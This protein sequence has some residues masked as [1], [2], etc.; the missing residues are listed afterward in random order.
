MDGLEVRVHDTAD[1]WTDGGYLGSL[2]EDFARSVT[3]VDNDAG[4]WQ[5]SMLADSAD[6][7][8][9]VTNRWL[10]FRL[11]STNIA[12]GR[13]GAWDEG[14][15]EAEEESAEIVTFSG[16]TEL[17]T[18]KDAIVYP[19][20][21]PFRLPS[22]TRFFNFATP[23]YADSAD[24]FFWSAAF[25]LFQQ[26]DDVLSLYGDDAP[27][28]WPDP[29]AY[30]IWSQDIDLGDDPPMPVG[31]TYYRTEV[32]TAEGDHS[33]FIAADD[34]YELWVDGVLQAAQ[35]EAFQWRTTR[36]VDL[37]LAAGSHTVAIKATNITRVL[38][39]SNGAAVVFAMYSTVDG[40]ELDTLVLH[41]DSTWAALGY[42][43]TSPGFTAGEIWAILMGE[44][45]DREALYPWDYLFD[46]VYDTAGEFWVDRI[47]I[48]FRV[49][50]T[51]LD[52]LRKLAETYVDVSTDVSLNLLMWR[53]GNRPEGAAVAFL[54]GTNLERLHRAQDPRYVTDL[55]VHQADGRF[56][57]RPS[58]FGSFTDASDPRVEALLEAGSAPD[59]LAAEPMA[60]ALLEQFAAEKI[61]AQ[62]TPLSGVAQPVPGVDW[63]PGKTVTVDGASVKVDR[64]T[65]A[66]VSD[67]EDGEVEGSYAVAAE[68]VYV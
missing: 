21:E 45:T 48:S 64:L 51:Y 37:F 10:K 20:P 16:G 68:G 8:L 2:S 56:T 66:D 25:E 36:K 57:E 34:G 1:P 55:L 28:S 5:V 22:D 32:T 17:S 40:G 41:S 31:D 13:V 53:K 46:E 62:W 11:G 38:S 33:L 44:A 14:T 27:E 9:L 54:T 30:W 6:R 18:L 12:A 35:T 58:G 23:E 7:A 52:V 24:Y 59:E 43:T 63:W 65:I 19:H 15:L 29:T 4:T 61:H 39:S 26:G 49:G 47:A 60:D 42:P 67:S 50:E 3:M